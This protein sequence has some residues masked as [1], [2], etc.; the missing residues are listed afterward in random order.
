MAEGWITLA[1]FN[2]HHNNLFLSLLL[3]AAQIAGFV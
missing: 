2:P 3:A 1:V